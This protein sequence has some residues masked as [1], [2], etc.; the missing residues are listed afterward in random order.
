MAG[1]VPGRTLLGPI[2]GPIVDPR[3]GYATDTMM[4]WMQRLAGFVGP[5]PTSGAGVGKSLSSFTNDTSETVSGMSG[6]SAVAPWVLEAIQ[7]L[8]EI[9]GGIRLT[10][11]AFLGIL[12]LLNGGQVSDGYG[13]PNSS[14]VGSI[15]DVYLQLDAAGGQSFWFKATGAGTD[16]GW[17]SPATAPVPAYGLTAA[18]T[19][20]GTATLLPSL[21]RNIVTTI[22]AGTGVRLPLA[23]AA[24]DAQIQV[25]A[26]GASPLLL[27]PGASDQIEAFGVNTP[28]TINIGGDAVL[29]YGG[30]N[31]WYL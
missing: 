29:T 25:F 20:Q 6:P 4:Q 21:S 31:L 12:T 11:P 28:V 24:V 22:A 18:G 19:T 30:S 17:V 14:L 15:G 1:S 2:P 23:S 3:S 16:T 26:R 9:E 7:D 27:Y 5:V 13:V 10:R 8:M